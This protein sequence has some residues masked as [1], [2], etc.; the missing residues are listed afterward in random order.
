[1]AQ[2]AT[3]NGTDGIVT[4]FQDLTV[5]TTDGEGK[6]IAYQWL[7]AG[8]GVYLVVSST[9]QRA[10]RWYSD[11]DINAAYIGRRPGG[12]PMAASVPR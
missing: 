1:M 6:A 11:T 4:I 2:D 7:G 12:E 9:D 10:P 5:E 8:H 3:P